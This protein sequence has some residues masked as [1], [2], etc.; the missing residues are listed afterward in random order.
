M[1]AVPRRPRIV[2]WNGQDVPP[3]VGERP[4]GRYI[5]EAVDDE[6]PALSAEEARPTSR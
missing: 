6:A 4:A 2:T 3:E 1:S 5:I